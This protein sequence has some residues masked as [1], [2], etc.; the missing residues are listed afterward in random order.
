MSHRISL[1]LGVH[2]PRVKP[3]ELWSLSSACVLG[4]A[5]ATHMLADRLMTT[6]KFENGGNWLYVGG[7]LLIALK[8][9]VFFPVLLLRPWLDSWAS[10]IVAVVSIGC[11]GAVVL[12]GIR[13]LRGRRR[14]SEQPARA[15]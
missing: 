14:S 1:S 13:F 5:V 3:I 10:M 2:F 12:G 4:T 6:W 9:V 7:T 15:P 8:A 11:W